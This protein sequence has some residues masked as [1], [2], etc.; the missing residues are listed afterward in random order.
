MKLKKLLLM[1]PFAILMVSCQNNN[2]G[3]GNTLTE[4]EWNEFF[5]LENLNNQIKDYINNGVKIEMET[6]STYE[7]TISNMSLSGSSKGSAT[8]QIYKNALEY[9]SK[10]TATEDITEVFGVSLVVKEDDDYVIHDLTDDEDEAKSD[11]K[12]FTYKDITYYEEDVEPSSLKDALAEMANNIKE[13][14]L[15]SIYDYNNWEFVDGSYNLKED[16]RLEIDNLIA[17]YSYFT[18]TFKNKK[19]DSY[20]YEY[21][22]ESTYGSSTSI[23][24]SKASVKYTY[25]VKLPQIKETK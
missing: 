12:T 11:S 8:V 10:Y 19:Y 23:S 7:S 25:N 4:D 22:L 17:T 24:T 3:S 20:S 21:K 9:T 18:I 1:A 14:T 16:V 6:E 5:D 15:N 13:N 2:G